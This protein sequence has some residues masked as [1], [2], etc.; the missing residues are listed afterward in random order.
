MSAATTQVQ[1]DALHNQVVREL[2]ANDVLVVETGCG[3]LASAKCGLPWAKPP[4]STLDLACARCV[5]P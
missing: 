2:L 4:W 5:K 1:Q 3:A